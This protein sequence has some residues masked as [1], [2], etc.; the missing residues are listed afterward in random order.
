M[1]TTTTNK[2]KQTRVTNWKNIFTR[3]KPQKHKQTRTARETLS[4]PGTFGSKRTKRKSKNQIENKT[5]AQDTHASH[6]LS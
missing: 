1:L 3:N 4:N 6:A 5:H 2:R